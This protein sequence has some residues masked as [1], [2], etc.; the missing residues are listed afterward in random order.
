MKEK[1]GTLRSIVMIKINRIRNILIVLLSLLLVVSCEPKDK[2]EWN[3]AWSA[4]K[5]Y[6]NGGP[7]VEFFYQGKSIAGAS[8]S[9]GADP[10]WGTTSGSYAGG[11]I[12]KP[13]PDSIS[14]KWICAIDG[15]R[16][17]GGSRLPQDKMLSLFR[18]GWNSKGE[19]ENYTQIIAGFAP[20]GNVTV[21]V[22]GQGNNKE[23]INFKAKNKGVWKESEEAE[24]IEKEILSS[25][26]FI[27]S[28]V[29]IY[30]YLHGIP[31]SAWE[32]GDKQY[33]YDLG[34]SS[35]EDYK[36]SITYYSKD[37]SVYFLDSTPYF[38]KWSNRFIDYPKNP[39]ES[40]QLKLPVQMDL[41]W[42]SY[43]NESRWFEGNVL[44][45]QNLQATFE[46]G[47]YDRMIVTIPKDTGGDFVEGV[48]YFVNKQKQDQVMRFRLGRFN[49]EQ[50]KLMSPKYTLPK[51]FVVPKW[52][53][54]IPLKKPTDLEYWQEE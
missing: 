16:Y 27:N 30:R 22:S 7:F 54:R 28:E 15:Y 42:H 25:E 29:N 8:A 2:F 50:K 11:D 14:V 48:I 46:K 9:I 51:G 26:K 49:D 6:G 37:G 19:K 12:F 40:H 1:N 33:K 43:D 32:K 10:G 44:L 23:I 4:P 53:G 39:N 45:P 3:A 17:E 38:L 20:G 34:F 5:F 13:V 47:H 36:Y 35:E 31:Y 24:K 52:E 41:I 18:N 21:W